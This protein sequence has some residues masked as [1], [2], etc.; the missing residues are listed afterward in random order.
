MENQLLNAIQFESQSFAEALSSESDK[1][2][3]QSLKD[4]LNLP[5]T[6][7]SVVPDPDTKPTKK[8]PAPTK[9]IDVPMD[10]QTA[11]WELMKAWFTA[12]QD[13]KKTDQGIECSIEFF[14]SVAT[15]K[16][17]MKWKFQAELITLN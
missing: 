10:V 3:L 8:N 9:D 7:K 14:K 5:A 16:G 12:I 1:F 13:A 4:F 17:L 2:L 6:Y 11:Y 15:K